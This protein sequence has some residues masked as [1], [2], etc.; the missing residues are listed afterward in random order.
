MHARTATLFDSSRSALLL[1]ADPGSDTIPPLTP[2]LPPNAMRVN[3]LS[4]GTWLAPR[5]SIVATYGIDRE[6]S[7]WKP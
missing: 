5:A 3:D 6:P 2:A 1:R 4:R 7:P